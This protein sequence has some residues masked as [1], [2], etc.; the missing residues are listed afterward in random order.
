MSTERL[1]LGRAIIRIEHIAGIMG[2]NEGF[3]FTTLMMIKSRG[4]RI[5]INANGTVRMPSTVGGTMRSTG[6]GLVR[7]PEINAAVPRRIGKRFNTNGVLVVP[8]GRNAKIVTNK[9]TETMLRLTKLASIET[10]SLKSGGPEGVM[11]TAVRKLGSLGAIRRVTG[12]EKG[13]IRRLL[14]WKNDRE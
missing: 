12:L 4:K 5:N 6:G 1:S 9:P 14:K 2:N 10:G 3:E 7:M 11:G 8:T 13:G